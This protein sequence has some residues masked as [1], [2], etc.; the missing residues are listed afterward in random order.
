MK[1]STKRKKWLKISLIVVGV[2]IA[3][4]II[5]A[6][7]DNLFSESGIKV[8]KVHTISVNCPNLI[9][10]C[11]EN[12]CINACNDACKNNWPF[13]TSVHATVRRGGDLCECSCYE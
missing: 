2:I 3:I 12:D 6:I 11:S 1:K 5:G 7:L 10:S 13:Y 4:F 8:Q 9:F